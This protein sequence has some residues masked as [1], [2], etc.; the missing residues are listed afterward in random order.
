MEQNIPHPNNKHGNLNEQTVRD[1]I[2][3]Q[4][5]E[6]KLRQQEN[7]L[8]LMEVRQSYELSKE[9]LKQQGAY[10]K[11][12]PKHDFNNRIIVALFLITVL[13]II[14]GVLVYCIH[15]GKE[16]IAMRILEIVATAIISAGGGYA[17]GK[18]KGQRKEDSKVEMVDV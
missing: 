13:L 18:S 7:Q 5:E 9:S 6:L 10:L 11:A 15:L 3:L 17:W 8:R 12:A 16:E 1:F 14:A 2:E 4:K